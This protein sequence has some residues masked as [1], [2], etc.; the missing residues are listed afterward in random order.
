MI[1]KSQVKA[2]ADRHGVPGL[3]LCT[4]RDGGDCRIE[5]DGVRKAGTDSLI[6]NDDL[7]HIGSCTKF[8]TAC[9]AEM[10][11]REG[12]LSRKATLGQLGRSLDLD[13]HRNLEDIDLERLVVCCSG[14]PEDREPDAWPEGIHSELYSFNADPRAGRRRLT[15]ARLA[16]AND[17]IRDGKFRYSNLGYCLAGVFIEEA[18]DRPFE[19]LLREKLFD[20]LEMTSAG[21][22]APVWIDEKVQPWGQIG[23]DPVSPGPEADNPQALSPAGTVRMNLGDMGRYLRF[24]LGYSNVL[25]HAVLKDLLRPPAESEFARGWLSVDLDWAK[26]TGWVATGSN[27]NFYTMFCVVPC[28]DFA[29]AVSVNSYEHGAS[30]AC[31]EIIDQVVARLKSG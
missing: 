31:Q 3:G 9:L 16:Y 17:V 29:I 22:G 23:E 30:G 5:T 28:I 15:K 14:L 18:Y 2:I 10:A 19:A 11:I 8:M 12:R 21:F 25:E 13:V 24:V 26:G 7:F 6:E 20:P 27:G 4:V 1:R